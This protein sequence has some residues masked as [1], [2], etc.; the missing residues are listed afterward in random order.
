MKTKESVAFASRYYLKITLE[1]SLVT[2]MDTVLLIS[3][4]CYHEYVPRETI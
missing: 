2:L 4:L 3:G 1:P